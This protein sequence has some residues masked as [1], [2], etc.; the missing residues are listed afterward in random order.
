MVQLIIRSVIPIFYLT[1]FVMISAFGQSSPKIE[2]GFAIYRSTSPTE[3]FVQIDVVPANVTDYTDTTVDPATTY[4]Y[5][6]LAFN[7]IANSTFSNTISI[8]TLAH[9]DRTFKGALRFWSDNSPIAYDKQNNDST[10][11]TNIFVTDTSGNRVSDIALQPDISGN[12]EYTVENGNG[13]QIERDIP[14]DADMMSVINGIDVHMIRR[15]LIQDITFIPNIYQLIAMDVNMDGIISAGDVTQ[16][17][18]RAMSQ[19]PE[20]QQAWN[21][22]T[23]DVSNREPSKDWT[24]IPNSMLSIAENFRASATYPSDDL[25][26]Y[27][28]FRVPVLP[29]NL[30]L[31]VKNLNDHPAHNEI[32]QGVLLGDVNGN[33]KSILNNNRLKSTSQ[34]TDLVVFDLS[35]AYIHEGNMNIPV[36]VQTDNPVYS[37]DFAL[38]FDDEK[39]RFLSVDHSAESLQYQVYY[40]IKDKTLRLTSNSLQQFNTDKPLFSLRFAIL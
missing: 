27:S 32:Y 10:S 2:K 17:N 36:L 14:A 38:R 13:I 3:G 9:S 4:Y 15:V 31:P 11:I 6:V 21:Y 18:Q 5:R 23:Q 22:G 30:P 37:L 39:I 16:M 35:S 33:Y 29:N 1:V 25:K 12:F 28:K 7:S 34:T 19:I 40:N 26:G 8:T 20:Y 24:F